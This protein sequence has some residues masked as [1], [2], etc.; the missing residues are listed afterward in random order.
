VTGPE[1]MYRILAE[2]TNRICQPEGNVPATRK[3]I[4]KLVTHFAAPKLPQSV[5]LTAEVNMAA[6][7]PSAPE[8]YALRCL[9]ELTRVIREDER[10]QELLA[11]FDGLDES[12]RQIEAVIE[13]LAPKEAVDGK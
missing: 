11:Q 6:A 1:A 9:A 13:N 7:D 4:R 2:Q 5:R 12:N 3:L 8:T 10:H